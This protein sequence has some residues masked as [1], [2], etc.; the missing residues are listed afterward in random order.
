MKNG[1]LKIINTVS[2]AVT[3]AVNALANLLPIGIG[4]TGEVSE[5]Y[6]NLFTPAP[7]TFAIWGVIYAL[8]GLFILRQW[9]IFG[10]REQGEREAEA[11]GLWFAFSCAM[12]VGWI[13]AWHFDRIP[14]STLLIVGLLFC[15]A[16]IGKRISDEKRRDL[17]YLAVNVTFDLYFGW[18]IAA[19]IANVTVLLVSL[20]WNG[21][22]ISVSVWTCL[23]LTVGAVIGAAASY[24]SRKWFSTFAVIWAYVG[25][26]I[27]HVGKNG[28]DK[29][30][31]AVI[32]FAVAGIVFMLLAALLKALGQPADRSPDIAVTDGGRMKRGS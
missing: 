17:S 12:N 13:F 32:V 7:I 10:S 26:L 6:P 24:V 29:A 22:G 11:V 27:R 28:Y 4:T 18:I 3:V 25:I 5:K 14:L 15:L 23:V 21:F 20:K 8:T 2:F 9:G 1:T 16:M 30:Y 19:V 31:P